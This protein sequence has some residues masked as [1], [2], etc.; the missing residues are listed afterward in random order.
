MEPY[1]RRRD[2]SMWRCEHHH[3][4][5]LLFVISMFV[6]TCIVRTLP[7]S[8]SA[9]VCNESTCKNND[10]VQWMVDLSYGNISSGCGLLHHPRNGQVSITG[11]GFTA[12][13]TYSCDQ[14]YSLR[15]ASMRLCPR[16]TG[17]WSGT[18][19]RCEG[20]CRHICNLQSYSGYSCVHLWWC[21]KICDFIFL[22]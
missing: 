17:L 1:Y 10:S 4:Y 22:L 15:G 20:K 12:Q 16:G 3:E 2:Y 9:W 19:P 14:S 8:Q 21:L 13:A 6:A 7:G 18:A 5:C 11:E